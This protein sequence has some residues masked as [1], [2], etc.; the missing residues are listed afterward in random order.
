ME[1]RDLFG[2]YSYNIEVPPA[3]L[4]ERL[5]L[6]YADNGLGKTTVLRLLWHLLSAAPNR[7][8]RTNIAKIA[9]SE[10]RLELSD[11]SE[12][13]ASRTKAVDGPYVLRLRQDGRTI[14]ETEWPDAAQQSERF[15]G[16]NA[17]ELHKDMAALPEEL[18]REARGYL[19]SIFHDL[20]V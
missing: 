12:L 3:A 10:I 2:R 5:V 4:S 17:N 19:A 8:H 11:G 18:Q 6:F 13:R 7:S 20:A 14:S 16:W 9:F 1:V 15:T